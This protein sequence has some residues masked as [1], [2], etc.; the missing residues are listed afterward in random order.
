MIRGLYWN[1]IFGITNILDKKD[2]KELVLARG[3]GLAPM[4]PVVRKLISQDNE[5]HVVIDKSPFEEIFCKEI[6]DE[7]KIK[8]SENALLKSGKLSDYAKGIIKDAL[9]EGTNYIHIAGADIL[10]YDVINYLDDIN[11]N[12]VSL[13]CCNNFKICCV[14]GVCGVCTS[15]FSGDRVKRFCKEQ[16]DPRSIFEGRRF[17]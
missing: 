16:L 15:K 9:K 5:L 7:Y 11:T 17:I 13:S 10:T 8:V 6:L 1:G 4:I 3:I 12:D 14:E 2:N